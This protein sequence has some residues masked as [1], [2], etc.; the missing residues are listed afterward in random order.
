MGRRKTQRRIV[1]V[2]LARM[3]VAALFCSGNEKGPV[4]AGF[5][6]PGL[7]ESLAAPGAPSVLL[8]VENDHALFALDISAAN[9]P[10]NEGPLAG[11]GHFRDMRAA[12]PLL[13]AKDVAIL[14]QA[15][16]M[17]D[18][19]QRHGFCA[20]CGARRRFSPKRATN[21]PAPNANAEHFRTPIRS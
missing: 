16:A 17:I 6:K 12:A 5:V 1:T 13:P 7:C 14:G 10:A 4:E 2:H 18:W 19:H 8:G 21:A 11:L 3:A 9:D 20:R 15:K